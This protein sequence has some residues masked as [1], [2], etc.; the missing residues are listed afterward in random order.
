[1]V[2]RAPQTNVKDCVD[3]AIALEPV[4]H[5]P[6]TDNDDEATND[7]ASNDGGQPDAC[8]NEPTDSCSPAGCTCS[9]GEERLEWP[10]SSGDCYTCPEDAKD[11]DAADCS[12]V[13]SDL[14]KVAPKGFGCL[15]RDRIR[16]RNEC[17]VAADEL[18]MVIIDYSL[19][20]ES[21]EA[22]P[23]A[24]IGGQVTLVDSDKAP[25]GLH[26]CYRD[27]DGKMYFTS[28]NSKAAGATRAKSTLV[29]GQSPSGVVKL[30]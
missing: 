6:S 16:T 7:E 17:E 21:R 25:D 15:K 18:G 13:L 20:Y 10:S 11:P 23:K 30:K 28:G 29:F 3:Y 5:V 9:D 8:L 27:D 4:P 1:M 26:G 14:Y 12:N 24:R 19:P 2:T 22:T